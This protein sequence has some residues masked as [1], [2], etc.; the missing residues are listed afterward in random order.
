[1]SIEWRFRKRMTHTIRLRNG[2]RILA[3]QY[4]SIPLVEDFDSR[5]HSYGI[6]LELLLHKELFQT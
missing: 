5:A 4:P 6:N 3:S 2:D 1:M